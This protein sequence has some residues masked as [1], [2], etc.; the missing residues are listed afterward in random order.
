MQ[1]NIP[2]VEIL[3]KI[4]GLLKYECITVHALLFYDDTCACVKILV[5]AKLI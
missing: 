4:S 5:N 1:Y 3:Y 2:I